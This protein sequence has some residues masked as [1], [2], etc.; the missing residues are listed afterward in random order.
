MRNSRQEE[1]YGSSKNF[2]NDMRLDSV[3][4]VVRRKRHKFSNK[5]DT[6]M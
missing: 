5:T 6:Q 1:K 4:D 3:E 2:M